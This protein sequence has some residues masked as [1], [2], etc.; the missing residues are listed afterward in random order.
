MALWHG[1]ALF[2]DVL[3]LWRWM[4]FV[5]ATG[6]GHLRVALTRARASTPNP[7]HASVL[8]S[9]LCHTCS[10]SSSSVPSS[11]LPNTIL[12]SFFVGFDIFHGVLYR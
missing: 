3:L 2:V 8:P 4:A 7:S 12:G 10:T 9:H 5:V 6:R 11:S 1:L